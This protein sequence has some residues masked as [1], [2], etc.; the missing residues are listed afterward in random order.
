MVP[1]RSW[2]QFL[3]QPGFLLSG[4]QQKCERW[5]GDN[6]ALAAPREVLDGR[7][8][9]GRFRALRARGRQTPAAGVRSGIK[10]GMKV[11][12]VKERG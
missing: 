11:K 2:E 1:A 6:V 4:V 5:A 10:E 3:P 9:L 12:E 7:E 8:L